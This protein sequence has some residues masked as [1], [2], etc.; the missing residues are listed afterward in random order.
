MKP[1][2]QSVEKSGLVQAFSIVAVA[3]LFLVAWQSYLVQVAICNYCF[4]GYILAICRNIK[5]IHGEICQEE[6][7]GD[8]FWIRND[9]GSRARLTLY[10]LIFLNIH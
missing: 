6:S 4:V 9:G 7:N 10:F 2:S 3:Y 5:R 8:L 1:Q